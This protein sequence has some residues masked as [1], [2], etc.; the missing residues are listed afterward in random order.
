MSLKVRINGRVYSLDWEEFDK[1]CAR[2][3]M[4]Y[5]I[6]ILDIRVGGAY[7]AA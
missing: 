7:V 2:L 5:V 6:E 3:A 4:R 1:V